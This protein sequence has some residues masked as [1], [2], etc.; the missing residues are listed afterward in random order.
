MDVILTIHSINRWL[1]VALALVTVI[2]FAIGWFGSRNYKPI[3]RGLMR[4]VTG[5]MDLQALIGIILLIGLG[6]ERFR[7]EHAIT[8]IIALVILHLSVLW[9]NRSD[10]INYRNNLL[11]IVVSM[12]AVVFGVGLLPQGWA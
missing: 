10:K 1:I 5:L 11:A 8:M 7:I 6:I 4:G 2:K 12:I 9:R 3:D